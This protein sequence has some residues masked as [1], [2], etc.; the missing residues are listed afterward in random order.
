MK[1]FHFFLFFQFLIKKVTRWE[2]N[3]YFVTIMISILYYMVIKMN[4]FMFGT[5]LLLLKQNNFYENFPFFPIFPVFDKEG[6]PM[7]T[8]FLFCYNYDL[9]IVLYGHKNEYVHVRNM[10]TFIETE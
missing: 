8:Q 1:I 5:C 6:D 7:G 10:S 4:M 2:P 3:S 9:H